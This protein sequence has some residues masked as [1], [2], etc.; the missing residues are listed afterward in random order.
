MFELGDNIPHNALIKVVGIGGGGGN[1]I[2]HMMAGNIEGV[3]FICMNTDAQALQRSSADTVIQLGEEITKGL[4][5][6]AN[7]D[8]GREA[9]KENSDRIREA[10]EGTDMVFLPQE[11]VVAPEPEGP[12]S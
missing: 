12:P 4:G 2:Q 5:A 1:A 11:W 6:G 8:V 3:K 7:P 10:L 9:A